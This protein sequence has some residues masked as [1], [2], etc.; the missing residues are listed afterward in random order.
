MKILSAAMMGVLAAETLTGLATFWKITRRD[1]AVLGFTDWS[2]DIIASGVT[3]YAQSGFSRSALSQ[4]T[5]LAV[6]NMEISAIL[7]NSL[8]TEADLRAGRYDFAKCSVWMAVPSDTNFATYGT[9]PLPGAY[10]G[11]VRIEDGVFIADVVGLAWL[12]QQTFI[13]LMTPLCNAD[14]GDAR[15]S[16]AGNGNDGVILSTVTDTGSVTSIY[17]TGIDII[18]STSGAHN[19]APFTYNN[20][21]LTWTSGNNNSL[22]QEVKATYNSGGTHI[23]FQLPATFP[24]QAGDTFT[25]TAGCDKAVGTCKNTF[26]N[27]KNNRGFPL[28]PGLSLLYD[29]GESSG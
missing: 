15:C 22:Q 14:L 7:S 9:I 19:T 24:I 5:D 28:I 8:I 29:Y 3:Y 11:E 27:L 12:L 1:G 21:L 2:S 18:V 13:E 6:P 25:V 17:V 26:N 4:R 16:G 10:I 20:G 23:V